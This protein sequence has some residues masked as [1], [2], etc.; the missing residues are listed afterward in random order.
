MGYLY[1]QEKNDQIKKEKKREKM[2]R[3]SSGEI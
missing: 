1:T 3:K 2:K